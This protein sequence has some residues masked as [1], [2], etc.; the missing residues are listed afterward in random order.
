MGKCFSTIVDRYDDI[1]L[2]KLQSEIDTCTDVFI[3]K[4]LEDV[5][6]ELDTHNIKVDNRLKLV[7]FE[8]I[9]YLSSYVQNSTFK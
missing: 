4:I 6:K 2:E 7:L 3:D 9:K 5:L 8:R 1:I